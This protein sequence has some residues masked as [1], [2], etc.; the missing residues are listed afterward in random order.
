[1]LPDFYIHEAEDIDIRVTV[2]GLS[3]DVGNITGATL[4][5]VMTATPTGAPLVVKH[6]SNY[7]IE[8]ED[9]L[10]PIIRVHLDAA[11]TR[12][13]LGTFYYEISMTIGGARRV[14]RE[15]DRDTGILEIRHSTSDGATP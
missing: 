15:M 12:N 10:V 11:D 7:S 14:L 1:M 8:I 4:I 2:H 5:F 6:S 9:V 3:C 13:R